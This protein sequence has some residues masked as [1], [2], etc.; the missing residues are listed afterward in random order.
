M[1]LYQ[2]VSDQEK[3]IQRRPIYCDSSE[4]RLGYGYYFWEYHIEAAHWWGNQ[5]Y[6]N[7]YMIYQ[8]SYDFHSEKYF[9]LVGNPMHRERVQKAYSILQKRQKDEYTIAEVI[10]LLKSKDFDFSFWAIRAYPINLKS[11]DAKFN[12]PFVKGGRSCINIGNR[13]Q[14]CVL[15]LDFLLDNQYELVYPEYYIDGYVV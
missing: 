3:I 14:M 2:T 13:I 6:S 8:A 10:E 9:D 7:S 5:H 11:V 12:I 1:P 15:N 4:A